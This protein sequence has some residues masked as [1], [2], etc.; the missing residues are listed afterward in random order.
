KEISGI[1][2]VP[3]PELLSRVSYLEPPLVVTPNGVVSRMAFLNAVNR[4][5]ESAQPIVPANG[6]KL[7]RIQE[8]A[9]PV[10]IDPTNLLKPLGRRLPIDPNA[11]RPNVRKPVVDPKSL[12]GVEVIREDLRP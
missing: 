7:L 6:K 12:N 4:V 9:R 3:L 2:P 8:L 5:T 10:S 11:V 1:L